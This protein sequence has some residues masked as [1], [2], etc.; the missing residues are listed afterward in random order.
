MLK[1]VGVNKMALVSFDIVLANRHDAELFKR[2]LLERNKFFS[3]GQSSKD[4]LAL[5]LH[6]AKALMREY[7]SKVY[8]GSSIFSLG[9]WLR[10]FNPK[11]AERNVENLAHIELYI[12]V[13]EYLSKK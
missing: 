7:K 9:F 6:K 4:E 13:L 3:T 8:G 2:V 12:T 10:I 1:H 11:L 5:E